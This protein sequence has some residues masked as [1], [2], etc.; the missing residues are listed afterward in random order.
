MH[1][2]HILAREL[3]GIVLVALVAVLIVWLFA[4]LSNDRAQAQAEA[5]LTETTTTLAQTTTTTTTIVVD[6]NQRLCSLASVF[7]EDLRAIPINLV[8]LAGDPLAQPG[9]PPL[10][11]GMHQLGDI[12]EEIRQSRTVAA[13]EALASGASIPETTAPITTTV[14]PAPASLPTPEIIDTDRIDPLESGLLG[15]PQRVALNFYTASSTLRL[16]TISADFASVADRFATFVAIGEGARFDLEELNESE[17]SD[18]WMSLATRPPFGVDETLG[19][20]EETCS[21]RIG[22]GFVYRE[23][24]PELPILDEVFVPTP[25]DPGIGRPAPEASDGGGGGGGGGASDDG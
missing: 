5:A 1:R 20:I 9:S 14:A 7:R 12:P 15:E 13:A 21:I 25:V 8:N 17:F 22:T 3:R 6:D 23:E 16:G 24:A 18:Q 2:S 10:D 4:R 19:Y 11:V